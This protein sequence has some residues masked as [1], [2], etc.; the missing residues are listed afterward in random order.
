MQRNRTEKGTHEKHL[1]ID[2]R[3]TRANSNSQIVKKSYSQAARLGKGAGDEPKSAHPI[4]L[5][6]GE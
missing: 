1:S 2:G 6:S 3:S 5:Q 4:D